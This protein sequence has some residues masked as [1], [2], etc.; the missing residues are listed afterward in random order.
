[1]RRALTVALCVALLSACGEPSG[2]DTVRRAAERL[3][4]V[5]AGELDLEV[6]IAHEDGS[7]G[8]GFRVSGPF[9]FPAGGGRPEARLEYTRV[10]GEEEARGTLTA[11]ADGATM[12]IGETTRELTAAELALL[13]SA[14]PRGDAKPL[15]VGRWIADAERDGER[16]VHG[17]LDVAAV[18]GDLL[19]LQ[20]GAGGGAPDLDERDTERLSRA[21]E[22]AVYELAVDD[23]GAPRAFDAEVLLGADDLPEG[24]SG[25]RFTLRFRLDNAR[26]A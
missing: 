24:L 19:A 11:G 10:V 26:F 14:S 18:V 23:T 25:V 16:R 3:A 20:R 5:R 9:S 13:E 15:D 22:R 7:G 21:A 1:M 12:R 17:R 6:R 2:A 8:M 4:E